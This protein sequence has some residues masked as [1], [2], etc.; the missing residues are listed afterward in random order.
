M[1]LQSLVRNLGV[2]ALSLLL[3][4]AQPVTP[5][6]AKQVEHISN[7]H[8]EQLN[9]PY[10]WLREKTNPEVIRYLDAE[11]SYTDTLTSDLKP[12]AE[13]LYQ[14]M[15]GHIKQTDL[16]VPVRRGAYWYYSRSQEGQQYAVPCRK[17]AAED[18]QF[19]ANAAEEMLL[20]PNQLAQGLKYFSLGALVV[21]DDGHRLAYTSDTTGFRQY[22]LSVK[23]LQTGALLPGGAERVTSVQWC[24]DNRTLFFTTEDP[25]TKRS[26]M[27]WRQTLEDETELVYHETD[28]LYTIQLGRSKDQQYLFLRSMST[29]TWETRALPSDQ[30]QGNFQVVLPRE[31]GH[32]YDVEHNSGQFLMRTN[33]GGRNFR[34]VTAPARDPAP[35]NWKELVPHRADVLLSGVEVF[36]DFA[37]VAEKSAAL[38]HFRILDLKAKTFR[39][40]ALPESVYSAQIMPTPEFRSKTFRYQYQSMI[41]PP[42]VYDCDLASGTS[43]LLKEQEVPGGYD[44]QQYVTERQWAVAPDGVKVPL[45]IVYR[46]GLKRNGKAP[47][48]LYAYGSYGL[49]MPASFSSSRLVLLDR[50]VTFVIAHIRGG[51]DLGETWHDD[52]MLMKK[53]NTF[54][55]FI[56]SAEWLIANGWTSSDRLLIEG[57]SAGGLLMGAVVNMRPDLFKAVH[58]GVPFVDVMNTMLDASL[59]LT[60]QEYLEW[61]NPNE[62]TAFDYMRSYSPYDNLERKNYPAILVTTSLNDSQVMYWEPAKYVAKLR[63][64]KTDKNPLL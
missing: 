52:G 46:K 54:T 29:D 6:Q 12:F 37:V 42:S 45:S 21:S 40:V 38:E 49:G 41:T 28:K 8:G 4:D 20:D 9:D 11:N 10:F 51:N 36:Q 31:K 3:P 56:A 53:K 34:L 14:E 47:L 62:K 61:G 48:Y 15:L 26:N 64:L 16:S 7:W 57:R 35:K 25:I 5:P 63:Y 2:L 22:Q 55:D 39:E 60:V 44:R 32:K 17:R 18:G 58:A 27:L 24:A 50:G 19:S 13:T 1:P 59:P 23:D 33:Q 30:P 43:T